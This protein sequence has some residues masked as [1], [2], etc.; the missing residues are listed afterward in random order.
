MPG[1]GGMGRMKLYTKQGDDG[2]TGLIGGE[3][4]FKHDLR[5]AA[6]GE[7]D[8]TNAAIGLALSRCSDPEIAETLRRI[9][10]DLFVLGAELATPPG[11]TRDL[12]LGEP[13]VAQLERWIDAASGALP[14]L[15]QFILPG[16][17]ETAALF[18]FARTV[19]RRAE[20]SAVHLAQEQPVGKFAI[21]YL[22]RL[23]D[24]LFALARL[25]NHRANVVDVPWIAAR[26][27]P[28]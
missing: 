27:G 11:Q 20:R 7:I 25:T 1:A 19:C 18:H 16:G 4:V 15:R 6:Y 10:G 13:H 12:Q 5:V 28:S 9:Q 23:G 24:L 26:S 8:E 17:S 22:N 14:P 3:R 2:R 21:I